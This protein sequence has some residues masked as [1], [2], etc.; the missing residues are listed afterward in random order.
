MAVAL[1]PVLQGAGADADE[2]RESD[3]E[4]RSRDFIVPT[5]ETG[6]MKKRRQ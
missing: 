6:T 3:G 1:F 5:S 4:I 2:D